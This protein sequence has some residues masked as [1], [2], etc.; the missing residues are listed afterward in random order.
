MLNST[1]RIWFSCLKLTV[2]II[3]CPKIVVNGTTN[4]YAVPKKLVADLASNKS[5]YP[6]GKNEFASAYAYSIK[7]KHKDN[8]PMSDPQPQ[9]QPVPE[10]RISIEV[11]NDLTAVYANLAFITH[12]PAELMLDFAQLLPRSGKGKV[13]S[14][15]LMSPIHAKALLQA[16]G[17]NIANYEKQFG[18]IKIPQQPTLADQL[19]RFRSGDG[20]ENE[21]KG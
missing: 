2:L 5:Q 15:I 9:P 3:A 19:F 6:Y 8:Q 11:P 14:R 13:V 12:T 17:Q 7:Q 20:E 10:K 16:L 21:E 18:E 4:A 1:Y